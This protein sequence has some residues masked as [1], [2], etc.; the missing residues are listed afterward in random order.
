MAGLAEK[1]FVEYSPVESDDFPSAGT[2]S[3]N[4]VIPTKHES[5]DTFCTKMDKALELGMTGFGES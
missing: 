2:C 3:S 5:F 1:I 4:L